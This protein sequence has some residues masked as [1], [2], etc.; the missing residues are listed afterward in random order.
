MQ[1]SPPPKYLKNFDDHI[2]KTE[3]RKNLKYDF[4][5]DSALRAI[6]HVNMAT[7]EGGGGETLHILNWEN[8]F[9]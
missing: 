4:S 9:K 8:P 3:I 6:F 2:S 5:F 7:S 1:T